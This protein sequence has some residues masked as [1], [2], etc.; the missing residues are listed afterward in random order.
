MS[1]TSA[2][3]F[4]IRSIDG[5]EISLSTFKGKKILI[6]NTASECGFTPQYKELQELHEQYS[7]KL[8]VI[9][10]PCN[11]FGKQEPGNNSE[12]KSFCEKN[13]GVTFLITDKI[14]V[15]GQETHPLFKWLMEQNN[16]SFTGEIKWNFEKF[17][18]D[19]NGQLIDRFRSTTS[20]TSKKITDLL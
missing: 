6:V 12:I 3:D 16:P 15:K 5:E 2:H 4:T 10:F 17:L 7:D 14:T 1:I 13:Y 9:G 18:I 11:D 8:V 19:E 20:P